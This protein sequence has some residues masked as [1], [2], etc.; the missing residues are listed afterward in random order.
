MSDSPHYSSQV[1]RR[2]FGLGLGLILATLLLA[3]CTLLAPPQP[4]PL[5]A[6]RPALGPAFS[7]PAAEMNALP[8]YSITV[9]IDP[10]AQAYTGSL[11]ITLPVSNTPVSE[12]FF[13]LYPNLR[14]LDGSLEVSNARLDGIS[15]NY[16]YTTS[17]TAVRMSLPSPVAPG[18]TALVHFDFT[19]KFLRHSDEAYSLFGVSQGVLSLAN[20]YPILA[21]HRGGEWALDIP[22]PQGDIGFSDVAL[23]QV[24]VVAPVGQMLVTSGSATGAQMAGPGLVSYH[25]VQGPGREFMLL[26]S[27]RWQVEEAEAYGTHVRSYFFPEDAAAGRTA[28]FDAVAALQIYSDHFGPYPYHEMSVVESPITFR[29]QEFPGL[30]LIGNQTYN[31]FFK[32]LE[33]RVAHEVGHQWWYNQVGSDQMDAPWQDEGLTEF[34]MYF[35]YADRYGPPVGDAL[36]R[37]RWATPVGLIAST[38]KDMPIGRS[39]PEYDQANYETMVYAKGAL[40]F[41]T[42]RDEIG[43][44]AFDRLLRTYLQNYRWRIARPEDFQALADEV[45]GRDLTAFFNQ[46]LNGVK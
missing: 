15:V 11:D 43:P 46:W 38:P 13:R 36:R 21:P 22:D 26:L 33:N 28:L 12:L 16:A 24:T 14:Q 35:Y 32:D 6:Y 5:A 41:A 1:L 20:F 7:V 3:G 4:D 18:E 8:A 19:G 44:Q 9:R 10:P 37:S 31:T 23:Y 25:Y 30:N 17:H 2:L 34:S 40:F 39:V 42:L 29:G 27:P 45:S